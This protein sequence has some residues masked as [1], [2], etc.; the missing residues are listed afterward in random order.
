[1]TPTD[2]LTL[3]P[4]AL[5]RLR[6]AVEADGRG[7]VAIAAAAGMRQGAL[8]D[9]LSGRRRPSVGLLQRLCAA[10]GLE[11]EVSARVVLRPVRAAT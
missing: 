6:A 8:S 11:C 2:A 9:V 3:P 5:R 7:Q 1:M 10:V 4:T